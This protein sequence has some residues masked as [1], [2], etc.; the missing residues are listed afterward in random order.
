MKRA[1]STLPMSAMALAATFL[2]SSATAHGLSVNAIHGAWRVHLDNPAGVI[3]TWIDTD[4]PRRSSARLADEFK[5]ARP[6]V[7]SALSMRD[8][9]AWWHHG[10]WSSPG[11]AGDVQKMLPLDDATVPQVGGTL[12]VQ[13]V[14]NG[15]L[16]LADA[17]GAFADFEGR[18]E[19]KSVITVMTMSVR[20]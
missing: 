20:P 14:R 18:I 9:T 4:G 15:H 10:A 17:A 13:L 5:G 3:T 11:P 1:F 19:T 8:A 12:D 7:S 6:I 2:A 16:P